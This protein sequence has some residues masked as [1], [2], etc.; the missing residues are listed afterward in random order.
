MSLSTAGLDGCHLPR[1]HYRGTYLGA[2]RNR[3]TDF[4]KP[5]ILT[6]FTKSE[7]AKCSRS[8]RDL[9]HYPVQT[10]TDKQDFLFCGRPAGPLLP[11]LL[12]CSPVFET[13]PTLWPSQLPG[14]LPR[15]PVFGDLFAL[16]PLRCHLV[17]RWA[18]R[19]LAGL[20]RQHCL[21]LGSAAHVSLTVGRTY[22]KPCSL[23]GHPC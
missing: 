11:Q 12:S 10:F 18:Q 6:Y 14:G 20:K 3:I 8:R 7:S 5:F 9:Q 19:E 17:T 1:E 23:P 22:P 21:S 4:W 15:L 2:M 16:I 13:A